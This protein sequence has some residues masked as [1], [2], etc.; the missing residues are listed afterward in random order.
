MLLVSV[1][2]SYGQCEFFWH[3]DRLLSCS[4]R[5]KAHLLHFAVSMVTAL[6][7]PPIVYVLHV[8]HSYCC[9]PPFT[10]HLSLQLYSSFL[11]LLFL[12]S[13][14]LFYVFCLSYRRLQSLW[15]IFMFLF[16]FLGVFC[17]L[18]VLSFMK[19]SLLLLL[20]GRLPSS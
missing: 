12:C 3:A 20:P 2:Q 13:E 15:W 18:I 6:A 17:C 7:A 9:L 14:Y 4:E 1:A 11:L 8:V 16:E 10:F 5:S 19:I